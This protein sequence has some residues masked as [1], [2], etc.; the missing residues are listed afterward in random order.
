MNPFLGVVALARKPIAA[1][2]HFATMYSCSDR[3]WNVM[4]WV[5]KNWVRGL[6][7]HVKFCAWTAPYSEFYCKFA[8]A[9]WCTKWSSSW[10]LEL[11]I[12]GSNHRLGVCKGFYIAMLL[13]L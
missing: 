4:A 12:V 11:K 8:L 13:F 1:F 2:C 9:K 10:H 7:K 6:H 5:R 3:F